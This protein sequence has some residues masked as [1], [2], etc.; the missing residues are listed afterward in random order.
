MEY[1]W[2]ILGAYLI[3]SCNPTLLLG[4]LK[5]VDMRKS[6][7]GNLG[8]SNATIVLG[9]PLGI[10]AGAFD[11]GKAWLAVWL[12]GAL[13]PQAEYAGA[14]AGVACVVGHIFPFYNRFRGGKGFAA[15]L[16]MTLGLNWKLALCVMAAVVVVTVLTDYIVTGTMLT[17]AVVPVCMGIFSRSLPMACI[18]LAGSAVVV[19]V[20]WENFRQVLRGEFIGL[21]STFKGENRKK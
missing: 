17:I 7:S 9:W 11:I 13:F 6:G 10:A 16:G 4:K 21:R 1:V 20:H 19:C 14:A 2:I 5:K 12:A 15:Y 18:L 3:G 8:A